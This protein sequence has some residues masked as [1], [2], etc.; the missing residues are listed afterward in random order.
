MFAVG[1]VVFP[2]IVQHAR[3]A[4]SYASDAGIFD[5]K[6]NKKSDKIAMCSADH[7]VRLASIRF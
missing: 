1:S 2:I 3:L 4:Q 6:W 7:T 5:V